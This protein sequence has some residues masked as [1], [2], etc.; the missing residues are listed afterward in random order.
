MKAKLFPPR[1]KNEKI[2]LVV[3]FIIILVLLAINL[4]ADAENETGDTRA[5]PVSCYG[6]EEDGSVTAVLVDSNGVVQT[7]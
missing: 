7:Y 4:Y 2:V 6:I 5:R 3:S 1:S